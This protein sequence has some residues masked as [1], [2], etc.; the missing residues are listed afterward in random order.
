MNVAQILENV[1][2]DICNDYCKYP[3]IYKPEEHDDV[4]LC[5]SEICNNCP[6]SKLI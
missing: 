6:L 1:C 2:T 3:H 5:D 4:E